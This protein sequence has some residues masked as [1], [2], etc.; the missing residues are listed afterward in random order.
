MKYKEWMKE[1]LEILVKP[2]HK[3]QTYKKYKAVVENH[4][5]KG[6]GECEIKDLTAEILQKFVAELVE[7]NYST[8]TINGIVAIVK[9]SLKSA[10]SYNK[11][12]KLNT[13]TIVLPKTREKQVESFSKEEQKKIEKFVYE[14]P[15]AKFFGIVICLYSGLRIGE[16]LALT[17][18]DVDFNKR[19]FCINKTC[20][21]SWE[22]GHYNKI[23]DTPKT[24]N[25][26]R[27]IPILKELL[28]KLRE[29]KKNAKSKFV[30]EGRRS[31]GVSIRSYQYSYVRILEKLKITHR[32]FHALRHTFATRAIEIGM[33]VKTLAEILGHS[34]PMITLKR[35]AH[36]M[37][38]HKSEMINKLSKICLF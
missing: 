33:D 11:I 35:Y 13:D 27:T 38:E 32:G 9:H 15:K 26:T 5:L 22:K 1:W 3:N 28:P 7:K 8:N 25:S 17:W 23:L 21:D 36:C 29:M 24:K 6:L 12:D 30:I 2:T 31:E 19:C 16:L 14:S 34:N 4:I 10:K 37:L 18:E 20:Y